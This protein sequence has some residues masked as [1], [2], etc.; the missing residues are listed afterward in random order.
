MRV[1]EVLS[2]GGFSD[3][4]LGVIRN[5]GGSFKDIVERIYGVRVLYLLSSVLNDGVVI[6]IKDESVLLSSFSGGRVL[7]NFWE[8]ESRLRCGF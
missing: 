3:E 1:Y 4:V 5:W 7:G 2:C 8:C 6:G